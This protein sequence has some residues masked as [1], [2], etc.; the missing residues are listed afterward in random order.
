MILD[1]HSHNKIAG[2]HKIVNLS[3]ENYIAIDKPNQFYSIGVHPWNINHDADKMLDILVSV[4]HHE[5]II[6]IGETGIDLAKSS[7]PLFRQLI[8]F[9]RHIE[10]SELLQK[11]LIIHNV[12]A[13]DI[14]IGLRKDLKPSMPWI[15]HGFRN[16]PSVAKMLIDA[17]LYLSFGEKFNIDSLQI[18]PNERILAETDES[19]SSIDEIIAKLTDA[20]KKNI[21]ELV[22][23]NAKLIF[24]I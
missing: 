22:I 18:T 24:Q 5:N 10:L 13:H 20:S 23:Q 16:K 17:G 1:I 9:K 14:I 19:E 21:R 6:A 4:A 3:P 11:P 12:K 2:K 15:I 8:V 7:A